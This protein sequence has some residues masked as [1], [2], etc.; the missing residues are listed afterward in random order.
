[1]KKKRGIPEPVV[2]MTVKFPKD[3]GKHKPDE[4]SHAMP[5]CAPKPPAYLAERKR[6]G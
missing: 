4:Q 5:K 3:F 1:M 2:D 6:N